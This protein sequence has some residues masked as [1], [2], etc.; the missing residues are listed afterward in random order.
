M[1]FGT[2]DMIASAIHRKNIKKLEIKECVLF[3]Y[4][5][6]KAFIDVQ[7]ESTEN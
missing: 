6:I 7:E 1:I 4:F 5:I 2:W 3:T